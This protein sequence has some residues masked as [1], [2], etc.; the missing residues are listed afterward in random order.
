[1]NFTLNS[2]T[3]RV[4]STLFCT[5]AMAACGGGGTT[6]D[7]T[8]VT[9]GFVGKGSS[10]ATGAA[11]ALTPAV[12]PVVTPVPPV[13]TPSPSAALSVIT[14]VRLQNTGTVAL[15]SAP[16]TF[17]QV[18]AVGHMKTTD[19]LVGRLDDNT[20]VPLQV[21][22]KARHGDGSVRHAII[23]A[24]VPNLA[25]NA[26]LTMALAKNATATAAA[27]VVPTD[28]LAQGFT[29]ST[30]ATIN[31]VK[32]T[33]SVDTLLKAGAKATWLSGNVAN[34]WHVSAP[35]T[36]AAGVA[37][38]HL[39]ARFAVRYYSAVK[40]ARVDV[41]LENNW[42]FEPNPADFKYDTEVTVGGKVVFT[43]ASLV[44]STHARWRKTFWWGGDEP[45]INPMLNIP[46]LIAT[47]A[48]PNYDQTVGILPSLL[49]DLATSA[50]S[51]TMEPMGS[52]L[53][54]TYMPMT[55][56]H[57][58]IG[59]L[60]S[61]AATYL[62]T[63]DKGA[64][65]ATLRSSDLAGSF[66]SHYRDK[67]TDRPV[68]LKNFPYMTI[69]GNYGDTWNPATNQMEAFASCSNCGSPFTHDLPHQ[70]SMAYLPYLV[71]GD[72]YY[73]EEL[74]FWAMFNTFSSNPNYRGFD[75]GI[76]SSEQTRGQAWGLRTLADAAY[77]T[78]DAD[79]LKAD[80]NY[81]LDSNLDW[82][83]A[84]YTNNKSANKLGVIVNGYA[85]SYS[86]NTGIAPWQDDFFT[87]AVGHTA[88][89]GYAKASAL[90]AWKSKFPVGR[91][92]DPGVCWVDAAIYIL[93][94][95][96]TENSAVYGTLAEAYTLTRGAPFMALP[97]GGMAMETIMGG[98]AVNDMAQIS[99]GNMGYPSNLQPALAYSVDSGNPSAKA[100]W[101]L[102][103]SRPI[104]PDYRYGAQFSIVPR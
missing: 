10:T 29:A 65:E 9:A 28:L 77:I 86:A 42:A 15:T 49:T 88:D 19:V 99:D 37:H 47:R 14:D 60:P 6:A 33:A 32:Y 69:N 82:Y 91:M 76:L 50:K 93:N 58:D 38:P 5:T 74:Q 72:Y 56:A 2:L 96:P 16:V 78:P 4:L 64:R 103:M 12:T 1:M 68:S 54:T 80:L 36:T 84:T 21:D 70:P 41:T 79:V 27:T 53:W 102:F 43:K 30:S 83:N 48:V 62:L 92:T 39:T 63:M 40:K 97:C 85:Y 94:I 66:S 35:L 26:T 8:S 23:S 89:L 45:A 3:L 98:K 52:G 81:F 31:G 71:T 75:K 25:A 17:G 61:F 18:F 95:R 55:G 11:S 57:E 46:Y 104:K 34:E 22:I 20:L 100:A 90:L 73:L 101:A 87:S 67:K 24:I 51:A 13:V 59:L 44:H 7:G